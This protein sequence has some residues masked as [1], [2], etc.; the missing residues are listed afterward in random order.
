MPTDSTVA[1]VGAAQAVRQCRT[2]WADRSAVPT[3]AASPPQSSALD[4]RIAVCSR[5]ARSLQVAATGSSI[6]VGV[7]GSIVTHVQCG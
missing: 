7:S 6:L 4:A 1:T 2:S 5:V 3:A